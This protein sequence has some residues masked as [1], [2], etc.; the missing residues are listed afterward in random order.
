MGMLCS[1]IVADSDAEAEELARANFELQ[2]ALFEFEIRRSKR[3]VVEERERDIMDHLIELF[4]GMVTDFKNS[5]EEFMIVHGSPATVIRK[6]KELEALGVD[7]LVGEFD[8]GFLSIETV[9]KSMSLFGSEV[10]PALRG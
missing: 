2:V 9:L 10:I 4:R 7:T 8:F 3:Y 6:L 5:S 1:V